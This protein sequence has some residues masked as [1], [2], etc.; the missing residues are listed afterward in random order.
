MNK[1]R[2]DMT[3][4]ERWWW[5]ADVYAWRRVYLGIHERTS[6]PDPHGVWFDGVMVDE[7]EDRL[8]TK[9]RRARI[10]LGIE[11]P[12]ADAAE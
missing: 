3:N 1:Y 6:P 7:A 2:E 4:E 12:S 8:R 10:A 5:H 9:L 11:A